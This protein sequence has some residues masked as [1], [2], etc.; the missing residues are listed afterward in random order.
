MSKKKRKPLKKDLIVG[1]AVIAIL[2]AIVFLAVISPRLA[3]IRRGYIDVSVEVVSFENF[4]F[5]INIDRDRMSF[6]AF[7]PGVQLYRPMGVHN[8]FDES[9]VAVIN[10]HGNVSD[11]MYTNET[12]LVV[13]PNS[14]VNA[15]VY[16]N[17][18]LDAELG[19][20]TGQMEIIYY[21]NDPWLII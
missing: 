16:L 14:I 6:G 9:I 15:T 17:V 5:G 11:W 8:E 21:R 3:E 19:T 12:K 4:T 7:P 13:G 18:P 20:Y 1:G 10:F 2:L